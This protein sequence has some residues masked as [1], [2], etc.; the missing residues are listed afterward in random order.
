MSI[1]LRF[2]QDRT[3]GLVTLARELVECATSSIRASTT[4]DH[5]SKSV[6][7]LEKLR[8]IERRSPGRL[9]AE[10]NGRFVQLDKDD[11][12]SH[13]NP[14]FQL[15]QIETDYE[16]SLELELGLLGLDLGRDERPRLVRIVLGLD[17]DDIKMFT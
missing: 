13:F 8:L 17:P 15:G 7:N 10:L 14:N 6:S 4:P 16:R 3:F 12:L 9:K 1:P 5:G 2:T 11:S